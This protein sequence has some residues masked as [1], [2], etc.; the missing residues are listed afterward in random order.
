M[1][2]SSIPLWLVFI[3]AAGCV[4]TR[5]R[6]AV[7]RVQKVLIT[8][9]TPVAMAS[10]EEMRQV[11]LDIGADRIDPATV[12]PTAEAAT[13][14]AQGIA[15]ERGS[16]AAIIEGGG[17][18]LKDLLGTIPYGGAAAGLLGGLW[19]LWRKGQVQRVARALSGVLDACKAN[20]YKPGDTAQALAD[21]GAD[22]KLAESIRQDAK[23]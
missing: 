11:G 23:G 17:S 5:D 9:G 4:T 16:R 20:T 13:A 14:N 2:V 15:S 18:L 22:P 8:V 6:V 12:Q 1:R 21:A 7:V 3:L 19:A 10:A